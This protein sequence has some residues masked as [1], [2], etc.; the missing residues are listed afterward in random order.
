MH[1]E[2]TTVAP[3]AG[4]VRQRA[5]VVVD[6]IENRAASKEPLELLMRIHPIYPGTAV[7]TDDMVAG[8]DLSRRLEL[9]TVVSHPADGLRHLS[10]QQRHLH[11]PQN[12]KQHAAGYRVGV[13]GCVTK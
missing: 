12:E 1:R 13:C 9:S 4:H 3:G 8:F 11:P 2:W 10:R 7:R 6:E 5:D